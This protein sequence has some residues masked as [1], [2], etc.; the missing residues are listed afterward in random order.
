MAID[1]TQVTHGPNDE[2]DWTDPS[3]SVAG[4]LDELASKTLTAQ[5]GL[6]DNAIM[7]ADG[8]GGAIQDSSVILADNG[9]MTEVRSITG[10]SVAA[11]LIIQ[12]PDVTGKLIRINGGSGT[13]TGN[14]GN[15]SLR[16]GN[17][18]ATSGNG[19]NATIVGGDAIEGNGGDVTLT[20]ANGVGTNQDGGDVVIASG[21]NTG[22]GLDGKVTIEGLEVA[23]FNDNAMLAPIGLSMGNLTDVTANVSGTVYC[24]Y[25]GRALRAI[26]TATFLTRVTTAFVSGGVGTN[27]EV[28]VFTGAVV[29]NGNASLSRVGFTD[30]ATVF[31]STGIKAV[32]ITVSGVSIGDPLWL[33]WGNTTNDT[34]F[35]LRGMLA[36]DIQSGVFTSVVL[37]RLSQVTV[38]VTAVL[39]AATTVP[40]WARLKI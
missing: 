27:A 39:E 1:A 10:G 30:V 31:D 35:E 38:P 32:T 29:A 20:A 15:A 21:D 7:R 18:G 16:A 13:A 11:G 24:L 12:A 17:G 33:A 8:T 22:S 14:G 26:T 28:G 40:A 6:T 25:L 23:L 34:K 5:S 4:K 19:G 36:D 2:A 3:E 9:G 37:S